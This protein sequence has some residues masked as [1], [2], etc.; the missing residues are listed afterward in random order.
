MDIKLKRTYDRN[1]RRDQLFRN[2]NEYFVLRILSQSK[3][4]FVLIKFFVNKYLYCLHNMHN[5]RQLVTSKICFGSEK[6]G[7]L[8]SFL[9]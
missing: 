5:K 7:L 6:F 1:D 8:E 4:N 9:S 3:H 2:Q